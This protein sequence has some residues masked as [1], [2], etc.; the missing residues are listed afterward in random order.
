[1]GSLGGVK[2]C[3]S[4]PEVENS[5]EKARI[6]VTAAMMRGDLEAA[7]NRLM[8]V[9]ESLEAR[10]RLSEMSQKA[11]RQLLAAVKKIGEKHPEAA[12]VLRQPRAGLKSALAR[13]ARS[14]VRSVELVGYDDWRRKLGL[15][16]DQYGHVLQN[17][18]SCQLS[19]GCSNFCRRCNEW[20][21]AGVRKHFAFEAA[22]RIVQELHANGND[23]YALYCASDPLDYRCGD[24]TIVDLLEFMRGRGC[25][26]QFGLLTKVPRGS[27]T[28]ARQCLEADVDIAVSLT[29]KNK[30]R[31]AA[32]EARA[33]KTFKAHHDTVEL[34]IPAGLDE[35]FSTVKASITDNY[36]VE[37]TPE[38]ASMVIPTFTSALRPTG[39]Y[40]IPVTAGSEWYLK[41]KVGHAALPVEYFKPLTVSGPGAIEFRL[42]HLI[43]AQV[44]TLLLDS[45]SRGATPPGMMGL[46]EFLHTFA[47]A[48]VQ[49]RRKLADT[50]IANLHRQV[51]EKIDPQTSHEQNAR[52]LFST[53][54]QAYL[55][56]CD[57]KKITGFKLKACSFLLSAAAAYL[58]DHAD[59]RV[60]IAHLRKAGKDGMG[61]RTRREQGGSIADW[62]ADPGQASFAG[63]SRLFDRLVDNP[64]DSQLAAFMH[65]HPAV[66]DPVIDR[67]V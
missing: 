54:K 59:E 8:T 53:R 27:E 34:M 5:Y 38:G 62:L 33:G 14:Q 12:R 47:P 6:A 11:I 46:E 56:F 49:Q 23:S 21:L 51:M 66:Y 45:G 1:M 4:L 13:V 30:T 65:A 50:A 32:I 60:V 2:K 63:F 18:A 67:Y 48:S 57:L 28:L 35:D 42:D 20:A 55:D 41:K 10:P 19:V 52:S 9:S 25:Q 61:K 17:V 58:R 16:D 29:A 24:R 26:T 39:Q 44:E 40:R 15:D 31:V 36:G 3:M 22:Q 7:K 37:I 43:A 64:E